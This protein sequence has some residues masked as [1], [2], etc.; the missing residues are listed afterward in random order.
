[1]E[2]GYVSYMKK[3]QDSI[4]SQFSLFSNPLVYF[5]VKTCSHYSSCVHI[6][7]GDEV[8]WQVKDF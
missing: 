1:M 4:F 2:K 7:L 3:L 8:D 6:I 5:K